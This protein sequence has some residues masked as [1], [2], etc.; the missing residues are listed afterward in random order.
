MEV[1]FETLQTNVMATL[2]LCQSCVPL[3]KTGNYGRIV[4]MA[5]TLGSISE[6]YDPDSI[7]AGVQ[8]PAY[9]LSKAALNAVTN[10][11]AREVQDYNILVNSACPGWVQTDMGG[12]EAPLNPEQGADTP[13][14]LATLPDDGPKGGFYRDRDIIPW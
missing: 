8:S 13:I 1:V 4:N 11:V 14:W 6:M 7:Y 2:R 3:M 9:R 5:S 10:L 12:P